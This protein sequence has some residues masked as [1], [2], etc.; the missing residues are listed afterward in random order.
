MGLVRALLIS[1]PNSTSIT[2]S[3]TRTVVAQLRGV[4]GL[5]LRSE[6]TGHPGHATALVTGLTRD[7]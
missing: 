6:F 4:P 1:N 5:H 2:E 7:E 3:L